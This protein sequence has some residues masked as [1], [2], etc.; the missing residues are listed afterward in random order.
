MHNIRKTIIS[1]G[2]VSMKNLSSENRAMWLKA[3]DEFT[4]QRLKSEIHEAIKWAPCLRHSGED[5]FIPHKNIP[6]NV[7]EALCEI[8]EWGMAERQEGEDGELLKVDVSLL[9]LIMA[10]IQLLLKILFQPQTADLVA[11][12]FRL[13]CDNQLTLG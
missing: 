13:T 12:R 7:W 8:E 3:S 4:A 11:E 10:T 5:Y 2:A 9:D 6:E 1:D